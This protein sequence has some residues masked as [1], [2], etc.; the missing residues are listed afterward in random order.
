MQRLIIFISLIALTSM[1]CGSSGTPTVPP[2]P[3][4]SIFD[5][6]RTAYGFFPTPPEVTFASVFQMYKDLGQHADV[7]LLQQNIP[8]EEFLQSAN[9]ESG[10]IAD[11]K[12][13]YILAGQN[14]LE[15]V[16]VVDPLNGLNR[17]EFSG[18]PK[19]WDAN[20][21]NPD[22]R[23]AYTNYTMRVVREFH[24]R[25]LGLASE[26]NT[27]MDAFPDD[28]QNFVSLYHEVYAKIKSVSPATQVFVT[29]QWE[30][31]NNLFVSDPSEGTPYQP[32]WELVEAFEPNLDLW[33]ISSYPFGAFDSA[34][35]IPPGYYT[36]LLSRTDKPLAVAE[37]G[38]TSREVGPFHG[39]E[40]DQADYLNAIH[41]QIG[42][43]LTFWIYLILND[44]NLDSYAKLMQKQGVGDDDI[45]TLGLFGSVGLRE[46]D[47]TPKAA[48]KIW[49][50]FRK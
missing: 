8:W 13:Q 45:N 43:R 15:V 25:Y 49:D 21:T 46:F 48:L 18:L 33:V 35:K 6:G 34:S 30:H 47:G 26:I 12:N 36:P 27:Y 22:V 39:T 40:Q 7:I 19:N 32:S 50:S 11:M 31:L 44:F 14:N 24:P 9:V 29:F 37:G 28:A 38:F 41:T 20:F 23:T 17:L 1:A 42:G 5:S 4:V 3:Q 2:T 10:H 16:Y